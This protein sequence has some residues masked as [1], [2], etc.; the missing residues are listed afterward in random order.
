[1]TGSWGSGDGL[2][3]YVGYGY[4]YSTDPTAAIEF[5]YEPAQAG[6]Y[7]VRIAYRPHAN[8][9][10][11][12]PVLVQVGETAMKHIVNMQQEPTLA[13]GFF[14]LGTVALRAGE[15]CRVVISA[16]GAGGHA[17]ADAVQWIPVGN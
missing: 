4:V 16:E 10:A 17:C 13:Q 9:G 14:S 3:G 6:R 7:D 1:M 11:T 12:V 2:Q 5:S 15:T 8:R